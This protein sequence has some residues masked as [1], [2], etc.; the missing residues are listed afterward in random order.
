MA[1][2]SAVALGLILVAPDC[3]GDA[4]PYWTVTVARMTA[5]LALALV[6]GVTR[7]AVQLR[8]GAVP[9]LL[10]VGLLIAAA[11]IFFTSAT[12][13]GHLSI[14]AVLGWLNPAVTIVRARIVLHERLRPLQVAA[15]ALVFAGIVC[16]TPG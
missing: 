12:T 16:I 8:R 5:L 4:D 1:V 7:P 11:D 9:V 15:A 2:G 6:A 14:V 10:L 3:G 13:L